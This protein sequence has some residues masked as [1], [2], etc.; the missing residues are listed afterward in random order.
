MMQYPLVYMFIWIIPTAIRIYHATGGGQTPLYL[1]ILDKV[2][3]PARV[4]VC[5]ERQLTSAGV[6]C[7]ARP[8]RRC[9]VR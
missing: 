1:N 5:A 3:I 9:G 2:C 6:H 8:R 7:S 4:R